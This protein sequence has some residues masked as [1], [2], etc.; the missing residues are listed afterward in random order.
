MELLDAPAGLQELQGIESLWQ[1]GL[2]EAFRVYAPAAAALPEPQREPVALAAALVE[3]ALTRQEL[4]RAAAG[5]APLLIADLCLARASRLLAEAASP[6]L[7]I[8][9][10][11]VVEDAAALAASGSDGFRLR[12][13]LLDALRGAAA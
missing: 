7:Q 12:A 10:A 8:A 3:S 9:F 6:A 5:P 4:G 1:D 11:R 13:R 2:G